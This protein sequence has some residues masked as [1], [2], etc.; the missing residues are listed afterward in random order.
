MISARTWHFGFVGV[1]ATRV[2][3]RP[4]IFFIPLRRKLID[5]SALENKAVSCGRVTT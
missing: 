4:R 2:I 1:S 5:F 3:H